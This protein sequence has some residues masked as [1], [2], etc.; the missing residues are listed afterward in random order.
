[1]ANAN[2]SKSFEKRWNEV[3]RLLVTKFVIAFV[4]AYGAAFLATDS[5]RL[6]FVVGLLIGAC[7]AVLLEHIDRSNRMSETTKGFRC[8]KD[9]FESRGKQ[10]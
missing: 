7:A 6:S 9:A 3:N 8:I 1:M 10:F 4:L 5:S 2:T